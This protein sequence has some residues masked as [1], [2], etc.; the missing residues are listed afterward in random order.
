MNDA[1][2]FKKE[3]HTNGYENKTINLTKLLLR[4]RGEA[5]P[6]HS[7]LEWLCAQLME[8]E[9]SSKWGAEKN[10]LLVFA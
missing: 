8:A 4:R 5:D 3:E 1:T 6:M 10:S 2:A 9:V 7:M